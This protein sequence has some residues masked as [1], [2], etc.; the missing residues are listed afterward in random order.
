MKICIEIDCI[1]FLSIFGKCLNAE[2]VKRFDL[3]KKKDRNCGSMKKQKSPNLCNVN[4]VFNLLTFIRNL[5]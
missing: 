3:E 2:N 1:I 5:L 4:S